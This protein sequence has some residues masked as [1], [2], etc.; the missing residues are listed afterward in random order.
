MWTNTK[1]IQTEEFSVF[2]AADYELKQ[3]LLVLSKQTMKRSN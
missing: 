3:L 1:A 2:V